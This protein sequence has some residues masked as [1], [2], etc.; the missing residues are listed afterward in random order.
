MRTAQ[1]LRLAKQVW[2]VVGCISA[3]PS[4]APDLQM[5]IPTWRPP[6][7]R[8]Q[9]LRRYRAPS[10][11]RRPRR[12][13]PRRRRAAP[14]AQCARY[15]PA[16]IRCAPPARPRCPATAPLQA[17]PCVRTHKSVVD[18]TPYHAPASYWEYAC[19]RSEDASS[20]R[21]GPPRSQCAFLLYPGQ[22]PAPSLVKSHAPARRPRPV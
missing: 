6:L 11:R 8:P 3:A 2:F 7:P 1:M 12:R 19:S 20:L 9:L 16:H 14:R 10:R 13:R 5:A 17:Q 21:R 4:C 22:F 18:A 15:S